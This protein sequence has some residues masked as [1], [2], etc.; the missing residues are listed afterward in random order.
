M[1]FAKALEKF[2]GEQ[3]KSFALEKVRNKYEQEQKWEAYGLDSLDLADRGAAKD[4]GK[5]SAQDIINLNARALSNS[6]FTVWTSMLRRSKESA[7][8]FSAEDYDI[9]VRKGCST[10]HQRRCLLLCF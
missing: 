10:L 3:R 9:K 8:N 7:A 1:K 2:I 6:Q 4:N 5:R